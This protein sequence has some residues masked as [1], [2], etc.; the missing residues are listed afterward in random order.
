MFGRYDAYARDWDALCYAAP[1][2]LPCKAAGNDRDDS[3][4][5]PGTVFDY[6]T[7]DGGWQY[8]EYELNRDP[9]PDAWDLGG[10]DTL[11]SSATAKNIL[12]IGAIDLGGSPIRDSSQ[13]AMATFSSWG[14]TDDGRVKP[15]LVAHGV[16]LYSPTAGTDR[17]YDVFSGTSMAT[18]VVAGAAALLTEYYGRFAPEQAM[19]SATLKALLIHTADDLG[20][21]GPDYQYGWGLVDANAAVEHMQAHFE[22]PAIGKMIE[23]A[24]DPT[25]PERS[26]PFVWDGRS[27][28]RVTLVWTD[29]PG[30]E[31][32]G[33]DNPTPCLVNDLD[34]RVIDPEGAVH[35]PYILAPGA[36]A[37][38][39]GTG[40]NVRDNIEQVYVA[41]PEVTGRYR[42]RVTH[43]G[44]LVGER[45]EYSLLLSGQA[46][47]EAVRA[48]LNG[49][50]LVGWL[51][52]GVSTASWLGAQPWLGTTVQGDDGTVNIPDFRDLAVHRGRRD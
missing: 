37:D 6:Y 47:S 40:D 11:P 13:V 30:L 51:D 15:D 48:D 27:A 18:P 43:K 16:D 32:E 35:A 41:G 17:S 1:Y 31:V 24:V 23:N 9:Y 26:H 14:P 19:R 7:E 39:A 42:V 34:L 3:V 46:R 12:T 36:P 22:S 10:Y 8:K 5:M 2:Y 49:D 50:G 52:S 33:L 20:N 45:Q 25:T 4:P 38:P 21:P 28:I 44:A 29:P